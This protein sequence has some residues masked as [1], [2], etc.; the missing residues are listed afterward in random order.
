MIEQSLATQYGILP[1]Q[2]PELSY[3]DWAK[4]VGGLMGETPLGAIVQIRSEK[5]KDV[6]KNYG[7]YQH[8]IRAEWKAFKREKERNKNFDI[9]YERKRM[10][11]LSTFIIQALK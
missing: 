1:S 9:E 8:R 3:S 7:P 11:E 10:D 4:L 6:I 5:N 2:Q